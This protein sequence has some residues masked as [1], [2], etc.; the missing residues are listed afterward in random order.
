M[1]LRYKILFIIGK[2]LG[3]VCLAF[4]KVYLTITALNN[5][6]HSNITKFVKVKVVFCEIISNL[7]MIYFNFRGYFLEILD[8][9]HKHHQHKDAKYSQAY[10]YYLYFYH[11]IF[12]P[13]CFILGKFSN[14]CC[15]TFRFIFRCSQKDILNY[16]KEQLKVIKI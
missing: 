4:K 13:F 1:L 11:Y 16:L 2:F 9:I 6:S 7:F 3:C 8:T 15:K 12:K 10:Y 5:P 14:I